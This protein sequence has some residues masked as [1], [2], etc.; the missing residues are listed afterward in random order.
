M[1]QTFKQ[2]GLQRFKRSDDELQALLPENFKV[3]QA[4]GSGDYLFDAIAKDLV[5]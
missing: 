3:G 1:H 4:I 2:T 5:Q